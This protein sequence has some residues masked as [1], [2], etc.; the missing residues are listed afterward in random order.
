MAKNFSRIYSA[1]P[2]HLEGHIVSVEI[3]ITNGLHSFSIVGLPDKAVEESRDRVASAIKNSGFTSPKQENHKTVVSLAPAELRK[4]GSYFDCAIAVGYLL[5]GHH[6]EF[7]PDK[8]LFIGE[9]SLNGE[10]QPIHGILPIVQTAKKHGFTELFIPE[11]NTLEAALIS[12]IT[13]YPA[14]NLSEIINHIDESSDTRIYIRPQPVTLI[15]QPEPLAVNNFNTIF[16]QETAKRGLEIAASGGHN[17]IMSGPPGTGK[18]LLARAFNELLPPLPIESILEVTGIHSVAGLLNNHVRP[19]VVQPPFRS[20]HHTSSYVSLIGGG[21]IPRPGEVTLAHRGVLF[22]DEFPEF[23]KRVI[24]SLR[25]PIE[26][27]MVTI[28]R[29]RGSAL[30]P[31]QFT[32]IAAMNPCP[33]GNFGSLHK[34]CVCNPHEIGRYRKKISGPILDRIDIWLAVEHIDYNKLSTSSTIPESSEAVRARVISARKTQQERFSSSVKLN[35]HMS[36]KDI[37][38]IHLTPDVRKLLVESSELFKLSP[39]SFH[40]IIKIARTIADLDGSKELTTDHILEAF[41]YRPRQ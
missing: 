19:L 24:E 27:R 6:I 1:Q 7:S 8:K 41:H 9:L 40:R 18:T 10:L 28:A 34:I 11:K 32:L 36:N 38:S 13:I 33:C 14:K 20:P 30:F 15:P 5:A 26:D 39:R 17:I 31:A 16:G 23:D 12:G 2:Y 3:D 4:E 25:Q 22:L 37:Q 29:A 21:S 35:A